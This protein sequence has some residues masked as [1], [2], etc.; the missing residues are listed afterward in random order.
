M[1]AKES[2]ALLDL[3]GYVENKLSRLEFVVDQLHGEDA[4]SS[5]NE[6][7]RCLDSLDEQVEKL[8]EHCDPVEVTV[9]NIGS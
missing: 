4:E 7:L 6:I 5:L 2:W 3:R 8:T 1:Q 9:N